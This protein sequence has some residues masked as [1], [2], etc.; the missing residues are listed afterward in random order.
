M[1]P[2]FEE[3]FRFFNFSPCCINLAST[4]STAFDQIID[5]L[6]KIVSIGDATRRCVCIGFRYSIRFSDLYG[7]FC[8][9]QKPVIHKLLKLFGSLTNDEIFRNYFTYSF[10][11]DLPYFIRFND[12]FAKI[13]DQSN[14]SQVELYNFTFH[15]CS[16]PQ[17]CEMIQ[18]NM[19]DW[20][21]IF[22]NS[23]NLLLYCSFSSISKIYFQKSLYNQS[24]N[25]IFTIFKSAVSVLTNKN[26]LIIE[27]INEISLIFIRTEFSLPIQLRNSK[28]SIFD[29][30]RAF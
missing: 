23:L 19:I 13:A 24:I 22:I 17:I 11:I 9:L 26:P 2:Y 25:R 16:F 4:G 28:L 20:K 30:F 8:T 12:N 27:S 1:I 6:S 7:R 14:E 15:A 10:L 3:N 18:K 5:F 21:A 29:L